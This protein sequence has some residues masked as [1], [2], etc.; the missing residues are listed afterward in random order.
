MSVHDATYV[1]GLWAHGCD[2]SQLGAGWPP[3]PPLVHVWPGLPQTLGVPPPPQVEGAL[4]VPHS[5]SPPQPSEAVPQ[6]IPSSAQVNGVQPAPGMH[7]P[8]TQVEPAAQS[9]SV[10]QTNGQHVAV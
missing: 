8:E 5:S 2:V 1:P 3:A 9:A 6:K 4:Q 10:A 7:V